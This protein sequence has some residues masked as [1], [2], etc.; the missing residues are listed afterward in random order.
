M[1]TEQL[2]KSSTVQEL[3]SG[4]AGVRT[5][6]QTVTFVAPATPAAAVAQVNAQI[7]GAT[8]GLAPGDYFNMTS[9]LVG[10]AGSLLIAGGTASSLNGFQ[11]NPYP[12]YGYEFYNISGGYSPI[13]FYNSLPYVYNSKLALWFT[14][15]VPMNTITAFEAIIDLIFFV[16]DSMPLLT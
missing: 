2:I 8:A 1:G 10:S 7:T 5:A 11:G 16:P 14:S 13:T 15:D 3:I 6:P 9:D 12:V 4:S